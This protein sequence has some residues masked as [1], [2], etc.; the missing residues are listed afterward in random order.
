MR[1]YDMLPDDVR[2]D[3]DFHV[4]ELI[5]FARSKKPLRVIPTIPNKAPKVIPPRGPD[6]KG[7]RGSW[8]KQAMRRA[9]ASKK[10]GAAEIVAK[11]RPELKR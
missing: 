6:K 5:A 10:V 9:G 4:Q 2:D 11:K 3:I 7:A 8:I 1:L